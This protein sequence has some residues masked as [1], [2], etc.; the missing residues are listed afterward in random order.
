MISILVEAYTMTT[1]VWPDHACMFSSVS[2]VFTDIPIG[3]IVGIPSLDLLNSQTFSEI[4]WRKRRRKNSGQH[5][6]I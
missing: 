3:K 6:K 2:N 4:P 1:I 5:Y